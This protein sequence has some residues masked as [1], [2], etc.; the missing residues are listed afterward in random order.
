MFSKLDLTKGFYQIG[1]DP[2]CREY[3][4]FSTPD[5][6]KQWK[7]MPFGIANAPAAFQREMAGVE[8]HG[9]VSDGVHR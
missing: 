2:K 9:R 6:L 7:V 5:G 8:G 3:L 4:A 1:L